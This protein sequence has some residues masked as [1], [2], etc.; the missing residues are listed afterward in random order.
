MTRLARIELEGLAATRRAARRLAASL[1][2]NATVAIDGDLGAG[3]TTFVKAVAEAV[4][5]DPAE[6][7]SP[8]FGIVHVHDVPADPTAPRPPRLVH[9]DAYRLTGASELAS[10]GWA[11]LE[12]GPGWLVVEWAERLGGSLPATRLTLSLEVVGGDS[13][14]L[15]VSAPGP[16]Y[17]RVVDALLPP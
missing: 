12:E 5:I 10:I 9:V 8:T 17:D 6:V 14:R 13:R 16:P 4:G 2:A 15:L 1:P 3:K 11:D 7:T